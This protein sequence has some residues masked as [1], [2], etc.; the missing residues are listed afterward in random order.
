M[1][2]TSMILKLC[3]VVAIAFSILS[4]WQFGMLV[5]KSAVVNRSGAEEAMQSPG[6]AFTI[7]KKTASNDVSYALVVVACKAGLDWLLDVPK[8]WRVLVFEKCGPTIGASMSINDASTKATISSHVEFRAIENIAS[9]ECTAYLEHII[10]FCHNSTDI[11]VFMHDDGLVPCN[12]RTDHRSAHSPFHNF[13]Q[14]AEA[15]QRFLSPTKNRLD[16]QSAERRHNRSAIRGF[17]HFGMAEIGEAWGKDVNF[18]NAQQALWP[19]YATQE[20]PEPPQRL[21]F[22]PSANMAVRKERILLRPWDV[23]SGLK[24]HVCHSR[25]RHVKQNDH[26]GDARQH[27]FAME[28]QWHILFG[29]PPSLPRNSQMTHLLNNATM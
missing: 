2:S 7:D 20:N 13:S 16:S 29:E 24:R 9:E 19:F 26:I 11:A 15:T 17:I 3:L 23:H 21:I 18:G 1:T 22:A 5:S 10:E 27:C 8:E 12:K 6:L 14:I 28:R 4:A 25:H